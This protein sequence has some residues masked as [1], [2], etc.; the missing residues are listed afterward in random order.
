MA[1]KSLKNKI[2][3]CLEREIRFESNIMKNKAYYGRDAIILKKILKKNLKKNLK[4]FVDS[5]FS[6]CQKKK[7]GGKFKKHLTNKE[8]R[9]FAMFRGTGEKLIVPKFPILS[10]NVR[11][12]V[13]RANKIQRRAIRQGVKP[14]GNDIIKTIK[15]RKTLE[16]KLTAR[17]TSMLPNSGG[18]SINILKEFRSKYFFDDKGYKHYHTLSDNCKNSRQKLIVD[19]SGVEID[20]MS[21]LNTHRGTHKRK[22]TARRGSRKNRKGTPGRLSRNLRRCLRRT[23]LVNFHSSRLEDV[24]SFAKLRDLVDQDLALT[25]KKEIE[26]Q[27][28]AMAVTREHNARL[29]KEEAARRREREE[30]EKKKTES[31]VYCDNHWMWWCKKCD[32]RHVSSDHPM[33]RRERYDHIMTV[34]EG[35]WQIDAHWWSK[36]GDV[37]FVGYHKDGCHCNRYHNFNYWDW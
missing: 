14:N 37:K 27:E 12:R 28:K 33:S 8:K 10:K 3:R 11:Q 9:Y 31:G 19:V 2:S 25:R 7:L 22:N 32:W 21:S 30:K 6:H 16:S 17:L 36:E 26:N 20:E 24:W 35:T 1:T 13:Q 18:G 5:K 23:T 34:H 29:V 4:D 15:Y